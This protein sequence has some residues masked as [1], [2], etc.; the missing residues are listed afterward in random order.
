MQTIVSMVMVPDRNLHIVYSDYN[1]E[2]YSE[3]RLYHGVLSAE[4]EW[5]S[6]II[7]LSDSGFHSLSLGATIDGELYLAYQQAYHVATT[8]TF[9]IRK[10][11]NGT[12]QSPK[13]I[14][15]EGYD[16][17]DLTVDAENNP[18]VSFYNISQGMGIIY[19]KWSSDL[20][21]SIEVIETDWNGGQM[22]GMG[23]SVITDNFIQPHISYAGDINKEYRE[24]LK[25]AWKKDGIWHTEKVDDGSFQSSGNQIALDPVGSINLAYNHHPANQLRF[26]TN[27]AGP[28]IRQIVDDEISYWGLEFAMDDERYGHIAVPGV[29][30]ALIPPLPYFNIDPDSLDFGSVEPDSSKTMILKL[31]NPSEKDIRIDSVMINDPRFTFSK[32]SFILNRLAVDSIEVSFKQDA[33]AS[34]V[35]KGLVIIYN[36][37]SGLQMEIP[38]KVRPWQPVLNTDKSTVEFGVVPK[39]TKV[40]RTITVENIGA[41]DLIFSNIE[42]RYEI[43]PGIPVQTDFML[44][45]HNCSTLQPGETCEIQVSFE[46]KK[47]GTQYSILNISS[48]DPETPVKKI[49]LNGST[50]VPQIYSPKSSIDFGYSLVGQTV[51]DT[52]ILFNSG[53]V[54]LNITSMYLSGGDMDQFSFSGTCT[55]ITPGD[56]C[57]LRLMM[58]P[59]RS[60]DF[61]TTL[62]ISSD[63]SY[64]PLQTVVLTGQ[65]GPLLPLQASITADPE[66]GQVPL[67]V[68]F[69]SVVTGG[70]PSY[71]YIWDF[72]DMNTSNDPSPSHEFVSTGVYNVSMKVTDVNSNSVTETIDITVASEGIPTVTAE[73][74]PNYGEI[75]LTVQFNATVTGGDAPL[76]FLWDFIDGSTSS[77][78]NP[79][80]G[81]SFPGTYIIRVTVTDVDGDTG[82]DSVL[83]TIIWNNSLA[84]Q[85]FDETGGSDINDSDV[86]LIPESDIADTT[87]LSLY[88]S[89]SYLFPGLESNQYTV[90]A[91][92]DPE[93]YP[94][95]LPTCLGDKIALF[96]AEWINVTGHVTGGDIRLIKKPEAGSGSG[97]ISGNLVSGSGKGLTIM[98][99]TSLVKSDPVPN[100]YVYLKG[101]TDGNLKAYDITVTDGSFNFEGLDNGDYYFI[102][103]YQGKSMDNANTPLIISDTRK[104]LNILAI[105]GADKI[106]VE[107]LTTGTETIYFPAL[108]V[109]PVPAGDNLIVEIPEGLFTSITV[110]MKI[111]D[112]SGKY[113]FID[114]KYET[115]GNPIILNI[116]F[117][118]NGMHLLEISDKTRSHRVKIVKLK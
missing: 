46:P 78:Q 55:S 67:T 29:K 73:A 117:L 41:T 103:D 75:P 54:E 47:D 21:G 38:V 112:L 43:W 116:E 109:Y 82:K 77:Q 102:T 13:M 76:S 52:L 24:N 49:G 107:D 22:E 61:Q 12:W 8:G 14:F 88:G 66:S 113:V 68:Y 25:H 35:N 93:A 3:S 26:A 71:S 10:T 39:N 57:I 45:G 64:K 19:Q 59:T 118:N 30:Y 86:I 23:T 32:T 7:A 85:L 97:S 15:K 104:D 2:D 34:E 48:N 1:W 28:W 70:Q 4:D 111:L 33:V 60:D 62:V 101:A 106:T 89:N 81:F 92:P 27:I 99:K 16:H 18:H 6:R 9:K 80:H 84:G 87:L 108:K 83:V 95:D 69:Q 58:T 5:N 65:A 50:P 31:S 20:A 42:V 74:L 72:G 115:T 53:D 63:D 17:I 51:T 56:S 11:V 90:H 110:R 100:A 114:N 79:V 96:E 98:E 94:E 40:T 44:E 37:P 105:V 36:E 91:V